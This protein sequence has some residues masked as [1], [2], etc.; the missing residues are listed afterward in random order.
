[1]VRHT[2]HRQV[3]I[4]VSGCQRKIKFTRHKLGVVIKAFKKIPHTEKENT[5]RIFLFPVKVL[6]QH[7]RHFLGH[8]KGRFFPSRTAGAGVRKFLLIH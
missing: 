4:H 5:F 8:G 3:F 7:G 1:M 6:L 2:C